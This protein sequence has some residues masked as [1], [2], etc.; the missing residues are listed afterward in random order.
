MNNESKLSDNK[1]IIRKF[2]VYK[3]IEDKYKLP[4]IYKNQLFGCIY[5]IENNINHKKYIGTTSSSVN[6]KNVTI[7]SLLKRRA[8]EYIYEYNVVMENKSVSTYTNR[9]I[10]QALVEFGIDNFSMYPLGET[11]KEIHKIA[12]KYFIDLFNT[13]N[14]GYNVTRGGDLS[15]FKI[16]VSHNATS[17]KNRSTSIVAI[18]LEYKLIIMSD[19]MKLFADYMNTSKDMIKNSV[20][21]GRPYKKW[22][23]FY[24]DDTKRDYILTKN[25]LGDGL[26]LN[27]RYYEESKVYYKELC[28]TIG[29][30]L[31]NYLNPEY[32]PGFKILDPLEYKD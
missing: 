3:P 28:N 15:L 17:K 12:E 8:S 2:L 27:D 6:Q 26:P 24:L 9:P 14:S 4:E 13:I 18:N 31:S 30:F 21:K 7:E 25:V 32:F 23:I 20:R 19:S 11:L 5:C 22:Y 29:L 16:G 10:I 1:D